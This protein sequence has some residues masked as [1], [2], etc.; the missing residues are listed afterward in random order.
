MEAATRNRL[1]RIAGA[2]LIAFVVLLAGAYFV[3]SALAFP[4]RTQIGEVTV[5]SVEKPSPALAGILADAERRV[6]ASD[7][8]APLGPRAIYL[9][10]GGWRWWLLTLPTSGGAFALTRPMASNIVVNRSAMGSNDVWNGAPVAGHRTLA[11]TIAHETTHLLIY[12]RYGMMAAWTIPSWKAE[13]YCDHVA[14]ESSLSPEDAARLRAEGKMPPALTYFD[15]RRR[16]EARLA[17]GTGVDALMR[18]D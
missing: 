13:G 11:G 16:V 14:Q 4:Y 3:P 8:A 12:H 17:Q 2:A 7:I 18:G 9:T 6:A 10:D 15:A 5:Y 1:G